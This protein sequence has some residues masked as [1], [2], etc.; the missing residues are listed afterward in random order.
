MCS[1][2]IGYSLSFE[3]SDVKN[4]GVEIHELEEEYFEGE[5]VLELGLST[6]HL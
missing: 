3:K 2:E 6:M 4:R 1:R 5:L